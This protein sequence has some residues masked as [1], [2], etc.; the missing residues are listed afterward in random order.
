MRYK[1]YRRM[2]FE[3]QDET[4]S[5]ILDM[6]PDSSM[7]QRSLV[8]IA[9]YAQV[10]NT[11]HLNDAMICPYKVLVLLEPDSTKWTICCTVRP[12]RHALGCI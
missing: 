3:P 12:F 2:K 7:M 4:S 8:P 11:N 1:G 10:L 6:L 9:A 5:V